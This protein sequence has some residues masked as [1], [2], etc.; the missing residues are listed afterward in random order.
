MTR[1]NAPVLATL[2]AVL[3]AAGSTAR[4]QDASSQNAT[5]PHRHHHHRRA[6]SD[7]GTGT[8]TAASASRAS[9]SS[10]GIPA[11]SIVAVV[12]GDA[13]TEADVEA[14]EKLFALST[15]MHIDP[16]VLGRLK[17]QI[18]TQLIDESLQLQEMQRRKIVIT[19]DQIAKAIAGIESRNGLPPH[20]L[21]NRLEAQ[22]VSPTTL[23]DQIRAQIGWEYVLRGDLGGRARVTPAEID[24]RETLLKSQEG[25]TEYNVSE[26]FIPV[27]DPTK[28]ADAERFATSVITQLRQGAPFG[29]VAAQFGQSENALEGGQLGWVQA[30][31][32]DPEVVSVLNQM[33]AGAISNPIRV[34]GGFDIVT[35][36]GKRSIGNQMA[37]VLDVREAFFP[38]SSKLDPQNPTAQQR[39]QL[40]KARDAVGKSCDALAAM[41]KSEGEA[42]P[43][44]PGELV[45]NALNPQM[46][47]VLGPVAPG[48]TTKPL[49]SLDGIA[50]IGVC[51]RA[52]KNLADE[53]RGQIANALLDERVDLASRQET[54]SLHRRAVIDDRAS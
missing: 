27:D 16:T 4:A 13:I 52:Q 31:R 10:T 40:A 3:L 53:S 45:L 43:T 29:I 26:I 24:A 15:G 20:A 25:Q 9:N 36:H 33:P 47:A 1:T 7:A 30:N 49:V 21:E 5:L 18:T 2:V 14:R 38:F 6:D 19:P 23:V 35:L 37:N 50:V 54:R 34:A 12:N 39:A 51:G 46:Q 44:D 11:D 41:N 32:L 8:G 48:S 22:G 17:P 28:A 42:R